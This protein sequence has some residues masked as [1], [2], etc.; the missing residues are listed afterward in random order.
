M[1]HDFSKVMLNSNAE[2]GLKKG[3]AIKYLH[4]TGLLQTWAKT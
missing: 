1:E 4:L 3:L 2:G